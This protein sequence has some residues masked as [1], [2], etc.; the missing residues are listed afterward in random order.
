M[1]IMDKNSRPYDEDGL[2]RHIEKALAVERPATNINQLLYPFLKRVFRPELLGTENLPDE[3]CLFIG[4]HSLFASDGYVLAPVLYIQEG[5]FLRALGDRFLWNEKTE[6]LLLGQGAVIGDPAVCDALM[7]NGSDLLV[8]PGGAHES[9]KTAAQRYS[10][11]W[12][13]RFGFVRMAAKHGYTIM[14][15]AM[16]GPDEFYDH[17]I[18]GEDIPDSPLGGVLERLGLLNDNTRM[19]L[20]PPIPRGAL[21]SLLPKPQRCYVQF[22]EPV[23]LAHLKGKRQSKKKLLSVRETVAEQIEDMIAELLLYREQNRDN[24]GLLRRILTL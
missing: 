22:G 6:A 2:T 9:T 3:P 5:R 23:R 4:N 24:E 8:Y 19:D 17:W 15:F 20:L 10:L 16:I 18:E 14:P 1:N 12:Q 13:D 11:Q 21:G 7:E